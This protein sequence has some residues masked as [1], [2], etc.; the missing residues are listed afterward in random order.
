MEIEGESSQ[1]KKQLDQ[2]QCS[3][4]GLTAK[5]NKEQES[6]IKNLEKVQFDMNECLRAQ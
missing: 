2:L 5:K 3:D 4:T 6:I 1:L